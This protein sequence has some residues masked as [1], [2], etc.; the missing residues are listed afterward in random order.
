[1]GDAVGTDDHG[2]WLAENRATL[3]RLLQSI[4]PREREVLRLRFVE[5]LTQAEIGERIGVSQMQIS[6][7]IRQSLTRLR[8]AAGEEG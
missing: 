7:L 1:M 3:D 6:R 4:G 8:A 2:F 5:D